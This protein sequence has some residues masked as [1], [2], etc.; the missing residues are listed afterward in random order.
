MYYDVHTKGNKSNQKQCSVYFNLSCT[1]V[2]STVDI[3]NKADY[4]SQDNGGVH[5]SPG[6]TL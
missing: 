4:C 1:I 5:L 3:T 2:H 6:L